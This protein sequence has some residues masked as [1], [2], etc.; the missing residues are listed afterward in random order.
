MPGR[1]QAAGSDLAQADRERRLQSDQRT[2]RRHPRA[3]RRAP[4]AGFRAIMEECAE[5][6]TALGEPAISVERRLEAGIEVGEH[7]TSMLQD[8]EAGK[9]LEPTASPGPWSKSRPLSASPS[10]TR[11]CCTRSRRPWRSC[12]MADRAPDVPVCDRDPAPRRDG[13]GPGGI[14]RGRKRGRRS[15]GGGL[16]ARGRLSPHARAARGRR[17]GLLVRRRAVSTPAVNGSGRAPRALRPDAARAGVPV[18]GV[19]AIT[20]PGAVNRPGRRWPSAGARCPCPKRSRAR[21]RWRSTASPSRPRWPGRSRP[22][23]A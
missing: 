11:R 8:R 20:V 6:A 21:P 5:V 14:R 17:D 15:P 3:A 13:R 2:D 22:S 7:K 12:A 9:P 23:R 4:D 18:R 16:R 19:G 10:R 1:A